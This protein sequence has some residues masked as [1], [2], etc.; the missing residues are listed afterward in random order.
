MVSDLVLV[1][2]QGLTQEFL[3]QPTERSIA[4]ELLYEPQLII[5]FLINTSLYI[6]LIIG[7]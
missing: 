5:V 7:P 2:V 3:L 1:G 6:K 4:T